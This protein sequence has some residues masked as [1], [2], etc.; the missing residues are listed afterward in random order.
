MLVG[1]E[2]RNERDESYKHRTC[3]HLNK[4]QVIKGAVRL[5]HTRKF[6]VEGCMTI[7]VT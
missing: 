5:I 3:I 4:A 2:K 7:I 1:G 6:I